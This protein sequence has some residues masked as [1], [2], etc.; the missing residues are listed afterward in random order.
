[1]HVDYARQ[2][3]GLPAA[4]AA[5]PG[6]GTARAAPAKRRGKRGGGAG[7]GGDGAPRSGGGR[8]TTDSGGRKVGIFPC[9]PGWGWWRVSRVAGEY[10]MYA[11]LRW[12]HDRERLSGKHA[13]SNYAGNA[14]GTSRLLT[15]MLLTAC[16]STLPGTQAAQD[17]ARIVGAVPQRGSPATQS[18]VN[19]SNTC[20]AP[21]LPNYPPVLKPTRAQ[22]F[23]D[24][25]NVRHSGR[26][27]W[28]AAGQEGGRA[29]SS[30]GGARRRKGSRK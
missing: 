21:S 25:N 7:R 1:M 20:A 10:C 30:G 9:T 12:A 24:A 19:A 5:R 27:A 23:I 15:D 13:G 2:F 18:P 8:W 22:V 17:R 6:G 11:W 16:L 29:R 28:Q 26:A 4:A 14:V 3:S